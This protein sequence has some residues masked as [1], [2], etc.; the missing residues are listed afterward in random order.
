MEHR[1]IP[2]SSGSIVRSW[3]L[4]ADDLADEVRAGGRELVDAAGAVDDECARRA[5]LHQ[6][7]GERAHEAGE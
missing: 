2:S 4:T 1:S 3:T 5:E 7:L 6:R